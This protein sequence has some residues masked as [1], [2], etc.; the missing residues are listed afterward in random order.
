MENCCNKTKNDPFPHIHRQLER[1]MANIFMNYVDLATTAHKSPAMSLI[2]IDVN[3]K[4][5]GERNMAALSNAST[6]KWSLCD[7]GDETGDVRIRLLD[8]QCPPVSGDGIAGRLQAA[9]NTKADHISD[10]EVIQ[11]R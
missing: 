10:R 5:M 8:L 6:E 1:S 2:Y 3:R 9:R 4:R 7:E 11:I